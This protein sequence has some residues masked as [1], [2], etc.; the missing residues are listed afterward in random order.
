MAK[1]K[2]YL[3]IGMSTAIFFW[4]FGSIIY[5]GFYYWKPAP[6]VVETEQLQKIADLTPLPA[7]L[8][9][10]PKAAQRAGG[11]GGGGRHEMTPPSRGRLPKASLQP[12]I[13]APSAH[14]PEIKQPSLP[15][16]PTI[17]VQ[18]ELVAKQPTNLP[19]GL[20]TGVPGPP[21]DGP[22]S[23]GGIGTGKGGGVG[24]GNGT[25][26]GPGN[27]WNTGGGNPNIGG[28]DGVFTA[29]VGGVKNP[30]I[31]SKEKPKYTEDARRDKIQG[32]VVL[33]AVF[34]KDG[35]VSD[36]KV[37]RGLGY[38]LDE[39]AVKAAAKIKFVPGTK[40]G[41]QVNVRAKLEFTF[42]LL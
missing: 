11:G 34:R 33:Q 9:K 41:Q 15:V 32:V 8:L 27:G 6:V 1:R 13:V 36:I 12:P 29:G 35:T 17:Q 5:F 20:P 10:A 38:G 24:S 21:S 7:E 14:P 3:R 40:D 28:G 31:L 16:I 18:P 2:R 25:G 42:S 30:Q 39:E 22:G 23:G 19:L 37:I 26:L 4:L